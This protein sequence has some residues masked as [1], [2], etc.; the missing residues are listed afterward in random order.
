MN[1]SSVSL[2]T[3]WHKLPADQVLLDL[4]TARGGLSDAEVA[5]RLAMYGPNQLPPPQ[6]HGPVV[7]F[8][9]QF[10]NILIYVLL[11][12]AAVT[13]LLGHAVDTGVI[14]GVVL[15]NAIVGFVQEGKAESAL[16]AIRKMLS[17]R[18]LVL[19]NGE[20]QE[21]LAEQLVPGDWVILQSG[22]KTPADLR[23]VETKNLRIQEAVLTGEAE[24]VE[25]NPASV[26]P[27]AAMGDRTCM[28][29]S[30]TLVTYGQGIGVVVATGA[31]TEIGRISALLEQV[32]SLVTPL[33]RQME[34]FGRWLSAA[35]LLMAGLTLLAGVFWRGL[36]PGAMFMAAVGLAVAA[37][38][39]GLP[40]ILTIILAIGV[41]RMAR[42][43][44]I[45]RH[46]PAVETLGAITVICSD[47]TGT[48]TR[49]EMTVQRVVTSDRLFEVSGGGYVPVGGFSVDGQAISP[50]EAPD[51]QAI[52]R[53]VHW[54][55]DARL[56]ETEGEWQMIGDPTEGALL[57]L[58]CKAGLDLADEQ[59]QVQRLDSI[60]FEAEH[61]FMATLH[62]DHYGEHVILVKG[63]PERV[64][65]MCAT[66]QQA[67]G[68]QPL[69]PEQWHEQIEA[70]AAAGQRVLA[71]AFRPAPN[72]QHELTFADVETGLTLLGLLGISDPPREEVMQAVR[73]TREAGIRVKMITG[74][75][76]VTARAIAARIGIGD[77]Q[78]A[79]TGPEL[80]LLDDEALRAVVLDTDVYARA[81]PEH[82]LRLVAALQQQGQVVAMTGDGVND[83]P[84]LKRADVGVAMGL[85]GTEAAK[86]ASQMVLADDHFASIIHA[87]EEGRTVYDNLR[88]AILFIL[89][90][91]GA[92]ALV[93]IAAILLGMAHLPV[94][95]VQILWVN[96]V[97]AVTLALALAFEPTE[98]QVM[99]R[100]P[101]DPQEPLLTGF[102]LWRIGLV[103]V[104]LVIMP[105]G[106]FLWEIG[107]GVALA[108]ARTAAVNAL[109]VGEIG[110]LFNSRYLHQSSLSREGLL[111]SRPV[112]ITS[113]ILLI[114]QLALTYWPPLQQVMGTA[115][116]GVAHWGLFAL[117]GFT[118]FL[119]VELEK[120]FWRRW[121]GPRKITSSNCSGDN[122]VS[123]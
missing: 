78:K 120:A 47:K 104:L 83:A 113:A 122:T 8:L 20:R 36:E 50:E 37:I 10:H 59:A 28:A 81:S 13:A 76:G 89:P 121:Q 39:E 85:K 17:L 74:D 15:I 43:N 62:H 102:M 91:N 96:M 11:A 123:R 111:G 38:P 82:K 48:L 19:R 80:D 14:L 86:E 9:L 115:P 98:A 87:V 21:I 68:L 35:I 77:G 16:A 117:A 30:S 100:P 29:Y 84:A 45:I 44:A 40:A 12:A 53:A 75:H 73:K 52:A 18:A 55:N 94:T 110:Y 90:T 88:K 99:R 6:R 60:P 114:L 70:L 63:A 71:V 95:P 119:L 25:K 1:V 64:L 66:Q 49:N 109:V 34:Q 79:L 5:R 2:K 57:T 23:L 32:E 46:L 67:E 106:L 105:L 3:D 92:Q 69:R 61:R 112:L 56:T 101:R 72:T 58:A 116:I 42:R 4:A 26:A 7:R 118:V 108:E 103:S 54:C 41:Q 97:T 65:A 24:A 51:L 27:D 31:A 107:Q 22:D 33:L 93:I